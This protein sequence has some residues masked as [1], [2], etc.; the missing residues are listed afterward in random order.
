MAHPT[1]RRSFLLAA[2]SAAA[3]APLTSLR[4]A[5]AQQQPCPQHPP[6]PAADLYSRNEEAYWTELRKQFVIPEDEVYLNNGTVGSSPW[7]VLQA[8]W[9]GYLDS[10][11]LAQS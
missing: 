8:V 5:D 1:D 2:A 6:L 9:D 10:E 11:R 4:D 7:P 3:L